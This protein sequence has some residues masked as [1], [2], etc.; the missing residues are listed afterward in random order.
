MRAWPTIYRH[1]RDKLALIAD[2]FETSHE[3][4]VP[5]SETGTARERTERLVRHASGP[6][7]RAYVTST[8]VGCG[9]AAAAS[10]PENTVTA[11]PARVTRSPS[12]RT[13]TVPPRAEAW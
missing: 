9:R 7:L 11:W 5:D 12:Q 6:A 10:V 2:A 13:R 3:T 8:G 1:W 4:M